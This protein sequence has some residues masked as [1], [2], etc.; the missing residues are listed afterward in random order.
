MQSTSYNEH[1]ALDKMLYTTKIYN[2]LYK[3]KMNRFI[4]EKLSI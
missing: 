1:T 4:I 3:Q 2:I